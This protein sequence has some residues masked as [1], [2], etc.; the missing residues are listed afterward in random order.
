[1][2]KITSVIDIGSNSA[3]MAIFKKTSRFGFHLLYELKAKVRISSGSYEHE[4]YLQDDA[5]NRALKALCE[6]DKI[7]KSYGA[8][9]M[10]CVATSATRDAPNKNV[11][12]KK[13]KEL[14]GIKIKVIPGPKEAYFGALAC[15]NLLHTNTGIT[16]DIGG[17]S[18]EL[19]YIDE[20]NI[21]SL[22]SLNLGSIRLKELYFDEGDIEGAKKYV[23]E[24]I[25]KN[26]DSLKGINI[27]K[28]FGIGGSIRSLAKCIIKNTNYCFDSL[29]GYENSSEVFIEYCEKILHASDS[30]LLEL[31]IDAAR[32]DSIRP[33]VLILATLLKMLNIKSVIVSGVGVREGVFLHDL[34][35]NSNNKFPHGFKPSLRALQDT[36]SAGYASKKIQKSNILFKRAKELFF[37]LSEHLDLDE[38]YLY[39][40]EI[41]SK[42]YNAG[43]SFNFYHVNKHSAY[44]A[45]HALTYGF[46]HKDRMLISTILENSTKSKFKPNLKFAPYLPSEDKLKSLSFILT[47]ANIMQRLTNYEY[48]LSSN[49]LR[50]RLDS[51]AFKSELL[52]I[53]QPPIKLEVV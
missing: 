37:L 10:F 13:V 34:L 15:A 8:R 2:S 6:F 31:N 17:G 1:M 20:G 43:A 30:E 19:A 14:T 3:R 32:L 38:K 46:S 25:S 4:A 28:C 35:R 5:I 18:T 27:K 22:L 29:H 7:S 12:L 11:F 48:S 49:L 41:A 39:H 40:L 47:V 33:G 16:M 21:K 52:A 50:I 26:M 23:K 44:L 51:L 24:Y 36:L 45:L 53:N 42:I 9:K